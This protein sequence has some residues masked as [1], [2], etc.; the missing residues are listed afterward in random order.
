MGGK[1]QA[2]QVGNDRRS[3]MPGTRWGLP[4]AG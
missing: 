3:G 4:D 1:L 2:E